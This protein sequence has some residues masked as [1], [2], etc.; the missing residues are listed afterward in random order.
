M[1]KSNPSNSKAEKKAR[2]MKQSELKFNRLVCV[3]AAVMAAVVALLNIK[4]SGAAEVNFILYVL[5]VLAI[6]SGV[7]L[8]GAIVW[9]ILSK[10]KDQSER[11]LTSSMLIGAAAVLFGSSMM[12]LF[13]VGAG[14]V[15]VILIAAL[16][17]Y[18]VHSIYPA[19]FFAYSL[20]AAIA[21][22]LVKYAGMS[23]P[24]SLV[25]G[26]ITV[27]GIAAI[28]WAVLMAITGL[29][30]LAKK[31]ITVGG[32][33]LPSSDAGLWLVTAAFTLIGG[34]LPFLYAAAALSALI[35][36]LVVYLIAVIARTV[37]MM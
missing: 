37:A 20:A 35:A 11:L 23:T 22:G 29:L 9:H 25:A 16:I 12:Y 19:P 33:S 31:G 18:A 32:V 7:A 2:Q 13:F 21:M 26:F 27:S 15:I 5:P 6:V 24:D 14:D 8:A 4:K 36:L 28:A 1:V 30:M 34:L 10:G 3:F 17:L